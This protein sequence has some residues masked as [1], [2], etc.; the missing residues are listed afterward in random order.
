MFTPFIPVYGAEEI[1]HHL[2]FNSSNLENK[3]QQQ[4]Q[5]GRHLEPLPLV[6][7]CI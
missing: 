3:I 5:N 2:D 7:F 6:E 1:I 4:Q